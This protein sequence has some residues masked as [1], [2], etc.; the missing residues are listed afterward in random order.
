MAIVEATPP[1]LLLLSFVSLDALNS[2]IN[3]K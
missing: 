1:I 3:N 2:K